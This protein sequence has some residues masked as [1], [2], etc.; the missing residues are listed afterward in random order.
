[1]LSNLPVPRAAETFGQIDPELA[2]QIAYAMS[3]TS[4]IEAP[5][6]HR[7]G[8]A[9]VHAADLVPQPALDSGPVE[10]VGAILNFSQAATR[11]TVLAGLD[12]DDADFAENVRKAIFTW[13]NIPAR[14][15]PRD[16]SRIT[17]EVDGITLIKAMAG[18]KGKD[19]PTVD[20]I[21]SALSSR[22]ADLMREE[23]TALGKVTAKD[24]EEA[25]NAV[26]AAIRRMEAAGD[27]FLIAAD[28]ESED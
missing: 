26:V 1:M 20:F 24:A 27:L 17:R 3:L 4:S 28:A 2:R 13:A 21:L 12:D 8:M 15:D 25:M 5:A 7:I 18:A 16:I 9:L 10:K 11:E 19:Q 6:L 14:I 22:L 23:I